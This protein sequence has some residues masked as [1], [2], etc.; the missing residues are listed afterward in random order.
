FEGSDLVVEDGQVS[1]TAPL[2]NGQLGRGAQAQ[3]ASLTLR[4]VH[5]THNV[6]AGI[7]VGGGSAELQDVLVQHT[8]ASVASGFGGRG[9]ATVNGALL[10]VKRGRLEQNHEGQLTAEDGSE[11]QATDLEIVSGQPQ[12]ATGC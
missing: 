10:T 1:N 5:L 12:S 6:E 8:A 2:S 3:G 7:A 4:R 9:I 11:I